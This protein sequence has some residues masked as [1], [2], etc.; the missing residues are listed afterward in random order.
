[1]VDIEVEIPIYKK[2]AI[3]I[4]E[5]I[6]EGIYSEGEVL[7]G[8]ST[9]AAIYNVSPETIR[10]AA[11]LLED[12]QIL[13]SSKGKGYIITSVDNARIFINRN[14]SVG[15]VH[16]QRFLINELLKE[17]KEIDDKLSSVIDELVDFTSRLKDTNH[18]VPLEFN[19][20]KDCIY[21]GKTIA[22]MNFW[23]NTGGTVVGVKRDGR[24]L[25]SPGPYLVLT[26]GDILI[27]VGE[28]E[29]LK[30]IPEFLSSK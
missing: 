1:M 16:K 18:I 26:E 4:A 30:S 3:D 24:L 15:N 14:K 11:M 21:I 10:R 29:I 2:I 12:M 20:P 25:L 13:Y 27:A 19:L 7:N 8:R 9:L 23:Q 6:I 22:E 28:N 17:K 5:R